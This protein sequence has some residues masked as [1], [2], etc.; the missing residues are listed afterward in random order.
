MSLVCSVIA[1]NSSKCFKVQSFNNVNSWTIYGTPTYSTSV[2]PPGWTDSFY[3]D[4]NSAILSP[5]DSIF[6]FRNKSFT[7][8][9]WEYVTVNPS[10]ENCSLSFAVGNH[11]SNTSSYLLLGWKTES[12]CFASTGVNHVNWDILNFFSLGGTSLNTWINFAFVCKY[13]NGRYYFTTFKNGVKKSTANTTANFPSLS[14]GRMFI[15]EYNNVNTIN[16]KGPNR[17]YQ[18]IKIYDEVLFENNYAVSRY[19]KLGYDSL[20]L[21]NLKLG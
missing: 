13:L 8:T 2:H 18:N 19:E 7:I 10:Y 15:G 20:I 9:W 1:D 6:N 16:G 5:T 14:N 4:S 3:L 11:A 12:A 17:Y 21:N